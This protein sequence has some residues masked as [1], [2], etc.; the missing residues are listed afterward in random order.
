[1]FTGVPGLYSAT[2]RRGSCNTIF[3]QNEGQAQQRV[4]APLRSSVKLIQKN[5]KNI[6]LFKGL[7]RLIGRV[8]GACAQ[9]PE[10]GL[11]EKYFS[12]LPLSSRYL[13]ASEG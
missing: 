10:P 2:P 8:M 12:Y 4:P 3:M 7:D 13:S 11:G 9:S 5:Q 6:F 1:M